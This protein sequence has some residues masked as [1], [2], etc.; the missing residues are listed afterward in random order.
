MKFS[1]LYNIAELFK[2]SKVEHLTSDIEIVVNMSKYDLENIDLE[3]HKMTNPKSKFKHTSIVTAT[4]N[5]I[6]FRLEEK[7]EEEK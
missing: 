2:G 6:N 7:D 3:L 1:D 5:G 4:I